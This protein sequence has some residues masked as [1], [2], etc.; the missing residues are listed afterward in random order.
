MATKRASSVTN[1]T[2]DILHTI[3]YRQLHSGPCIFSASKLLSSEEATTLAGLLNTTRRYRRLKPEVTSTSPLLQELCSR[4]ASLLNLPLPYIQPSHL[5][6]RTPGKGQ[7]THVD[8]LEPG[9]KHPQRTWTIIINLTPASKK[10]G[11]LFHFPEI[12][13]SYHLARCNA[14]VWRNVGLD[15]VPD[16]QSCH[17]QERLNLE[18]SPRTYLVFY[19]TTLQEAP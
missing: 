3:K 9:S 7:K 17:K 4:I 15:S 11:G 12:N 16:P 13:K 10:Q 14:L 18:A 6:R 8:Y 2:S 1:S 19:A 5:F